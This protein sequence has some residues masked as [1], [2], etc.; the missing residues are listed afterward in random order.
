[1]NEIPPPP[2]ECNGWLL[3]KYMQNILMNYCSG[4]IEES[5][6]RKPKKAEVLYFSVR[7][8]C[9]YMHE[10]IPKVLITNTW[11]ELYLISWSTILSELKGNQFQVENCR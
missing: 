9:T 2:W 10:C 6:M 5:R 8:W 1:V 7:E 3:T 4:T 11:D